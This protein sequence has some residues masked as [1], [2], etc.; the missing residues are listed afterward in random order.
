MA[1]GSNWKILDSAGGNNA[2]GTNTV[3]SGWIDTQ[4]WSVINVEIQ[5]TGTASGTLTAEGTNQFDPLWPFQPK[6]GVVPV[7]QPSDFMQPALPSVQGSPVA[8][9]GNVNGGPRFVRYK[10]ANGTGTGTIDMW[11]NATGAAS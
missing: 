7:P 11:V 3:Y 10:Y 2:T 9:T 4:Q 5:T 8:Y 1:I 6:P